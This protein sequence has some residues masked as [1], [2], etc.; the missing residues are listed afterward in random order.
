M[1]FKIK[2]QANPVSYHTWTE[3]E[4]K[5]IRFLL[6][7]FD[8]DV[9]DVDEMPEWWEKSYKSYVSIAYN[10]HTGKEAK[11]CGYGGYLLSDNSDFDD[12]SIL[13]PVP[14]D[15]DLYCCPN[16][17]T[18]PRYRKKEHLISL[19]NIVIDLDSHNSTLSMKDLNTHIKEFVP[20][21]VEKL[22]I[23]PNFVH[24]TGRG[25]H[26]W[27]CIEPVHISLDSLVKSFIDVTM[28]HIK[29]VMSDL[30]ET[31][32]SLDGVASSRLN[33]L[34]RFPYSYNSKAQKWTEGVMLHKSRPNIND[35]LKIMQQNGFHCYTYSKTNKLY[36]ARAMLRGDVVSDRDSFGRKTYIVD[37]SRE[38]DKR[39]RLLN[40]EKSDYRPCFMH[41]KHFMDWIFSTR[42]IKEG[43][44]TLCLFALYHAC[45]GLYE[46]VEEAQEYVFQ[47]N[48]MLS[49][50]LDDK[51]MK[52]N[53]FDA[54]DKKDYHFTNS[55][56]L[57]FIQATDRERAH[58]KTYSVKYERRCAAKNK[59]VARD[60]KIW[61][62]HDQG[63]NP[64][65]I[66]REVKC[67]RPTVYK[68][69]TQ[70]SF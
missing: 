55:S 70:I 12:E 4:Q 47:M 20:K 43:Q 23:K 58:F 41:R 26:L 29:K 31:E 46:S 18:G 28:T 17:L 45:R 8:C 14:A 2:T 30:N 40:K 68:V 66:A 69:L 63:K 21:L 59:K 6:M 50:P 52:N 49:N 60:T 25:V 13:S 67:S 9:P 32:L 56:F 39:K 19:Q 53:I 37:K 64:T 38:F 15:V 34:F 57:D 54:Y 33:G 7:P 5:D 36:V 51:Y 42:D 65:E 3:K 62:L 27:Y 44:R 35:N 48:A 24:Y 1:S 22:L 10:D 16:G 61:E 11:F